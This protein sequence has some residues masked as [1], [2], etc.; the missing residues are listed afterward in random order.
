MSESNAL[1]E[2]IDSYLYE[3]SADRATILS[4]L[5]E[6]CGD[7]VAVVQ[8]SIRE[9]RDGREFGVYLDER[10]ELPHLRRRF[11]DEHL[12]FCAPDSYDPGK[13]TALL[14]LL[15]GGGIGSPRDR[16]ELWMLGEGGYPFG[17]VLREMPC[18][19]VTPGNLQLPTHKRWSNPES[20]AYVLGVVEEASYR[21]NI[22]PDRV[23]I[24]GQSMGGFGAFHIV[25]T[26]GD[27]FATVG[28][29]AGAWNYAFFE[30][31]RGVDFYLMQGVND[32]VPGVRA[33][34]TEVA[35]ARMAHAILSGFH[36]PHTY[37]EHGGGHSFSDPQARDAFLGFL[38]YAPQKRRKRFPDEIATCSHKGA[39]RL[40]ESPHWFWLSLGRTHYGTVEIDHF[41][42]TEPRASYCTTD[43]RHRT[44]RIP[45]GTV[46]ARNQG[47]NTISLQTRNMEEVTLW[48]SREMVDLN[49]P[50]RV[51]VNG[52]VFH[53]D[54][55]RPSLA[56]ALQ[57][58]DRRRDPGMIFDARLDLSLKIDDHERQKE[59]W[60]DAEKQ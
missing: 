17:S 54:I 48:L 33:R 13:P 47:E 49:R 22:D 20:N 35:F 25:Q 4:E 46:H 32:H 41:E 43:F 55:V 60:P 9:A 1:H 18:I 31:L 27:R 37:V 34:W 6:V 52:E 42:P 45:G 58:Y 51:R 59:L 21:Y 8:S 57:S 39:F 36:L 12:N 26:I 50:V 14:V 38:D 10:F 16:G 24:A 29:H 2:L 56:A 7:P 53:E 44:I 40:Y 30:G 19:T 28:C 23:C 15:H 3:P 11:P 5:P